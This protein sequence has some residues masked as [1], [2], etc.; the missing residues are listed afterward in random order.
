MYKETNRTIKKLKLELLFKIF[1]CLLPSIKF[2]YILHKS[3]LCSTYSNYNFAD[4][5]S[6]IFALMLDFSK[7]DKEG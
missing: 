4:I 7:A 1:F 3:A 6:L 5:I 2:H